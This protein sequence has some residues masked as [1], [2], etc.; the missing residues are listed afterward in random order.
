MIKIIALDLGGVLAYQDYS[1]LSKHERLLLKIY[2]DKN[3][4]NLRL[5]KNTQELVIEIEEKIEDIYSKLYVLM[6]KSIEYLEVIRQLGYQ[7]SLWTN[8]R[9]AINKWLNSVGITN[10]ISPK[11]ICNSCNMPNGINKP[12]RKFYISALRQI[13]ALPQ[14]VL[15]V[16]DDERNIES[17]KNIGIPTIYYSN[18]EVNLI[19]S[20]QEKIK[21]LERK[22]L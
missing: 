11:Y 2:L 15:F 12:D 3:Y 17:A 9:T 6:E 13:Q 19:T 4:S 21:K 8:N 10:Y 14:Q 22:R 1:K 20:I 5:Q 7:S 18:T 16:D